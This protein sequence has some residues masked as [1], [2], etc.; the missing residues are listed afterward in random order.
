MSEAAFDAAAPDYDRLFTVTPLARALREQ[1]WARLATHFKA[2]DHVLELNCGT[3]EDAIW[4][5]QRGITVVATDVST[6]MLNVT[7]RK[8]H[9]CGVSELIETHVLDIAAPLSL[10]SEGMGA[11]PYDGAFSN[12]GGLN[13]VRELDPLAQFLAS[14][15]KPQGTLIL[16]PMN[17]WCAWEIVWHLLHG[18]PRTAFRRLR[19]DGVDANLGAGTL[20]VW[21]P[22]IHAL[23]QVFTPHFQ[24]KRVIGLGVGLPPSYL[25][26]VIA[27][28][29][30]LFRWLQRCDQALRE[31][32]PFSHLA[33]HVI[34]EFERVA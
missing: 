21:Y 17:R 7:E 2:G 18:Q 6:E 12:F 25:E 23:R 14:V 24:L 29:P 33:D 5:A 16:V 1:V 13:C 4:L 30:K 28:R 8:A 15:V 9:E 11:A 27:K 32:W 34:L 26:P 22:S 20:R 3:G 31:H 10:Q 19:R